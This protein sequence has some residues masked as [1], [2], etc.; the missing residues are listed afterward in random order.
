MEKRLVVAIALSLL[1]LLSWQALVSKTQLVDNQDVALESP[2]QKQGVSTPAPALA[3]EKSIPSSALI[4]HTREEF[5][6]VFIEP[7]AAIQEIN[8]KK[9]KDYRFKLAPAF[10]LDDNSLVFKKAQSS[11][12]RITFVHSDQEKKISKAF[13]FSK[14][15]YNIE[16]EIEIENLS[17]E[18]LDVNLPLSLGVLDFAADRMMSRYLNAAV[19]RDGKVKQI[20]AHKSSIQPDIRF[21]ALRERYFTAII[22]PIDSQYVGM[23]TKLDSQSTQIGLSP[24]EARL[25]VGDRLVEK[26]Y[27][28]LGPQDL[29]LLN[30]VHPEWAGIVNYGFFDFIS[31]I[32]LQLLGFLHSVVHNWG[33]SI[34][35]LSILVYGF[36]YPLSLKQMRSMKEMQALQPHIEEL[37]KLHK[38]NPQ[39][40]NKE[41]MELYREHK[42]NP[43]GG[44]LPLLL[45]MPIFVSLYQALM[46]SV[47]LRGANF[48]WIK[49]LSGPDRLF[50]L[51]STLPV[52]GN[53]INLLPIVMGIGMFFQQRM[54]MATA[55]S[56]SAEQQKF[57]MIFLPIIFTFIFYHMP[58]GLV[59]Y[60]FINSTLMLVNQ[61]RI[62]QQQ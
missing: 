30:S 42:V 13:I 25:Q 45:Q 36:L 58:S 1:I 14:S 46:R 27:I 11:S 21:L 57:M 41:I 15:L 34:V 56:G 23:I 35:I 20:N 48:L 6:L 47:V 51:P 59:L 31:Q 16:L 54:S 32:L 33:W 50:V 28:Y 17:N 4:N 8:F 12:D 39:K 62:K 38:D 7:Q 5:D 9:Y 18:P 22:E 19:G 29:K 24:I 49:D 52:I 61:I 10:F 44:C 26:F 40:L 43:L 3:L 2:P 60:W 37:R 53:E 55:A